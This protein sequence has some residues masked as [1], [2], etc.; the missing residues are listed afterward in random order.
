MCRLLDDAS[1]ADASTISDTTAVSGPSGNTEVQVTTT[2]TARTIST[3]TSTIPQTTTTTTPETAITARNTSPT[4]TTKPQTPTTIAT[5]T[6]PQTAT[7][8]TQNATTTTIPQATYTTTPQ[9]AT[10]VTTPQTTTTTTPQT[11]TTTTTTTTPATTTTLSQTTTT[12]TT[13]QTTTTTTTPQTTTT[14]TSLPV[15]FPSEIRP[16]HTS[17]GEGQAVI[18]LAMYKDDTNLNNFQHLICGF[19]LAPIKEPFQFKQDSKEY[20]SMGPTENYK[21]NP[22]KCSENNVMTNLIALKS[23]DYTDLDDKWNDSPYMY[24]TCKAATNWRV[25]GNDCQEVSMTTGPWTGPFEDNAT[26]N[27]WNY[28]YLCPQGYFTVQI[29]RNSNRQADMMECCKVVPL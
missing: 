4:T 23:Y 5:T 25:N 17:C 9:T 16:Q 7:T 26:T 20:K 28:W 13:P 11:T 19:P 18:G 22:E 3:T 10:T 14:T 29:T 6:T 21:N 27:D 15:T 2:T 24:K 1:L 8:T 12:T